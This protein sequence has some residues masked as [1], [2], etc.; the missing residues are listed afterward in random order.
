MNK[1]DY[2]YYKLHT[3]IIQK[4]SYNT[5]LYIQKMQQT[6]IV[7]HEFNLAEYFALIE[8][9]IQRIL[10]RPE[11][12]VLTYDILDTKKSRKNKLIVLKEKQRQM[13]ESP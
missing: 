7:H 6:S 12:H 1:I 13:K 11:N 5:L 8:H 2:N 3:R 4:P 10:L 9:S